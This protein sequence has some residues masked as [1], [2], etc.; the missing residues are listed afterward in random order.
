MEGVGVLDLMGMEGAGVLDSMGME[1]AG[2]WG[3]GGAET[4]RGWGGPV[5]Q[6]VTW[7]QHFATVSENV[8]CSTVL[9]VHMLMVQAHLTSTTSA[10]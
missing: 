1:S 10:L 6:Y 9:E 3:L 4:M 7:H 5:C 2:M 8:C